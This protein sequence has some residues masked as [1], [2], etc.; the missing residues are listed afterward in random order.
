MGTTLSE[1]IKAVAK[2]FPGRKECAAAAGVSVDMLSRYMRDESQP[3]FMVLA[4]MS[5]PV[6]VNLNWLAYDMPPMMI[7]D[8]FDCIG[9]RVE[10]ESYMATP[11]FQSLADILKQTPLRELESQIGTAISERAKVPS[12]CSMRSFRSDLG[13]TSIDIELTISESPT[14]ELLPSYEEAQHNAINGVA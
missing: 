4:N 8:G 7:A 5:K 14:T 6:G 13:G 9:R 1:R 3:A 11:G 10:T 2:L 12:V